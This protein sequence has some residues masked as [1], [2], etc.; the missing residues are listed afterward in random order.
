MA[1][2]NGK[3]PPLLRYGGAT[4]RV[5]QRNHALRNSFRNHSL[6]PLPANLLRCGGAT[7]RRL[8]HFKEIT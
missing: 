7:T 8:W 4:T 2:P 3:S 6:P 5:K 1:L